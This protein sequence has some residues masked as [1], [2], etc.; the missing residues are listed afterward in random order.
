MKFRKK[1]IVVEA[2]QFIM[3]GAYIW[4][5]KGMNISSPHI[6]E[7]NFWVETIHGDR[8]DVSPGDW[9]ILEPDGIHAYPCK[10]DIF[11]KTY[12]PVEE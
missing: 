9:I 5:P 3:E 8:I 1:P 2:G 11:E 12:E 7:V 6:G 4:C 10:P